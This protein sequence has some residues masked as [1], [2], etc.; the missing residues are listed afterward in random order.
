MVLLS[1]D[2]LKE[3]PESLKKVAVSGIV[4]SDKPF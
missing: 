4:T 2:L 1:I 3:D